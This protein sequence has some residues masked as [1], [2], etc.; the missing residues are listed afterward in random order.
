MRCE[1]DGNANKK[2]MESRQFKRNEKTKESD[3]MTVVT[4]NSLSPLPHLH[5]EPQGGERGG[6]FFQDITKME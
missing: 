2:M 1:K 5:S 4:Q 6:K 3:K